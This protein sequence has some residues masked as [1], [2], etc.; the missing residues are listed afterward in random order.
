MEDKFL[1]SDSILSQTSFCSYFVS[2]KIYLF[3]SKKNRLYEQHRN[4]YSIPHNIFAIEAWKK[5]YF[6]ELIFAM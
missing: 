6:V 3:T 4:D 5:M 1:S 2:W